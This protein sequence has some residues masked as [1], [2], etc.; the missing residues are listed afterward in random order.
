MNC[1]KV[2]EKRV[3]KQKS[4][5]MKKKMYE[6]PKTTVIPLETEGLMADSGTIVKQ[7]YSS[8]SVEN[9]TPSTAPW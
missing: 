6:S 4:K 7:T 3:Y 1:D 9:E 2:N 8:E 5:K